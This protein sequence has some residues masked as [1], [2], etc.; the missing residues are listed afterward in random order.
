VNLK[1]IAFASAATTALLITGCGGSSHSVTVP[2]PVTTGSTAT[3]IK[4]VVIIFG[5]NISFDHYFGTYPNAANLP[6]EQAFTA[7]PGTPSVNGFTT[8]LLT[9]N[10]NLNAANGA[11]AANPFRLSPSQASTADQDND[12]TPE[13]QAFDGGKLDLFP[14]FTGAGGNALGTPEPGVPAPFNTTGLALGFYDGNTVT[15]MW[16]Y[17]QHYAMS[18]NSFETTFG[19]ST[20]GAINLVSGQTNGAINFVNED[21]EFV[22][23]G[24][25]STTLVGEPDPLGDLCSDSTEAESMM[26][27]KNIGD[28]L[29]T[30]N[31]TWGWFSQGFDLTVTNPNGTTGCARSSDSAITGVTDDQDYSPHREPFQYYASTANPMHTRPTSVAAIGTNADATNHQ[32][33]VHDFYDALA[34]GNMPAVSFLKAP[35]IQTG[36]SGES[37]PLDEQTFIVHVLNMLEKSPDWSST[38]VILAYDDSDGWYDHQAS[39]IVNSSTGVADF[40][41][42]NGVCGDQSAILAGIDTANTHALGRCGYGPRLPML[43]VSPWSRNNFVDHTQVDQT[44]I[45]RFIEDN[46]LSGQRLGGGSFDSLAGSIQGMFDFSGTTPRN[47]QQLLLDETTGQIVTSTPS[48]RKQK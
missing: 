37:D 12:Y 3:P 26:G 23:G 9:Q 28:M 45:M 43:V 18:D 36:H 33:D 2:P 7:L 29:S 11:G 15:G 24:A 5:E 46:W 13:Q 42:G 4:H 44:S 47:S 1:C 6:G 17:A 10:P 27:G 22:D 20:L 48:A 38:A 14:S 19:D 8:A 16:N 21:D 39:P 32:Y 34:A 31:V 35:T 40:L 25:K 30:A 41:N